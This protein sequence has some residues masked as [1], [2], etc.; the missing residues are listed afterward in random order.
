MSARIRVSVC[1]NTG[2]DD[3]MACIA[4]GADAVGVLVGVRHVAED[5]ISLGDAVD[6]LRRVP[7]YIGRYA[8]THL[9]DLQELVELVDLLPIDA[10][11]LHDDVDPAVL[12]AV[13]DA[14]PGVRILK[15]VHVRSDGPA[16]WVPY[17]GVVDALILDSIDPGA[18]RIGG[19]G[20]V[21]DWSA[22]AQVVGSSHLPVVLAGGLTPDNVAEAVRT[23]RPWA[24]NVNSGV[25]VQARKDADK[26]RSFVEAANSCSRSIGA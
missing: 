19:T 4:G 18:D 3:V 1:A 13:R 6:V 8:V 22:S 9:V 12:R 5:A 20:K 23:V 21:H 17:A 16:E 15:A 25:E 24:V 14:R 2:A 10:L 11:Q 7:P 26:V